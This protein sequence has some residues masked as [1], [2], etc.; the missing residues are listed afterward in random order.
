[1][2]KRPATSEVT[3]VPTAIRIV[4][5]ANRT[6][7][8]VAPR[9]IARINQRL[10]SR[11]RR[12][13]AREWETAFEQMASRSR[14]SSGVSILRAGEGPVVAC[15]HGWEGRASQFAHFAPGLLAAGYSIIA[16]D[17]PAHGQSRGDTSDPYRF[18]DALLEVQAEVGAFRGVI[19]HSMGGG[20]ITIAMAGGLSTASVTMIAAPASL[21]DVLHRFAHAMHMPTRATAHFVERLR[22]SVLDRGFANRDLLEYAR[23]FITPLLVIH[24]RDDRE[25]P[26]NDAERIAEAW[27]VAQLSARDGLGHRRI[28]RDADVVAESVSFLAASAPSPDRPR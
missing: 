15:I 12:F 5:R 1:M 14:L 25:V 11:P 16:I 7:G 4:Q 20:A 18:A 2:T 21:H 6:L 3:D 17:G 24:S 8:A 9:T 13:S 28:L 26:F 23:G 27:P 22:Q 19:G 10:F